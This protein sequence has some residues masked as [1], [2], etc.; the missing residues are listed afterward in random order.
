MTKKERK[1]AEK[2]QEKEARLAAQQARENKTSVYDERQKAKIAKREA[3]RL[4]QVRGGSSFLRS[5][6]SSSMRSIMDQSCS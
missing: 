5:M 6:P 3:D 4:I 2:L 1:R